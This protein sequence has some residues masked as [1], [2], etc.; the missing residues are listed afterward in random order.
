METFGLR[1]VWVLEN[2]SDLDFKK[3]LQ[4]GHKGFQLDWYNLYVQCMNCV[5][6]CFISIQ[7]EIF[8]SYGFNKFVT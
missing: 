1:K 8:K 3:L 5:I 4:D 2:E 6:I 7:I